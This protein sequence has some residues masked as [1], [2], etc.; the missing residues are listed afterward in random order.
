MLHHATDN[1]AGPVVT[2]S[3]VSRRLN[4]TLSTGLCHPPATCTI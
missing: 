4:V 3:V 1:L 2:P